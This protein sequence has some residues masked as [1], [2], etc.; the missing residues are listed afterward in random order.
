MSLNGRARGRGPR[1]GGFDSPYSPCEHLLADADGRRLDCRSSETGSIPVAGAI[2]PVAY[3]VYAPARNAGER[4]STP[5]WDTAV[6]IMFQRVINRFIAIQTLTKGGAYAL[7]CLRNAV[8]RS[9]RSSTL[10]THAAVRRMRPSMAALAQRKHE[11]S[12][13]R[14]ALLRARGHVGQADA[15]PMIL[16]SSSH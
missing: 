11:P 8:S 2:G 4:G 5:R 1:D 15:A 6:T 10:G 9:Q 16:K 12:L 14:L 13:G 7:L 3:A